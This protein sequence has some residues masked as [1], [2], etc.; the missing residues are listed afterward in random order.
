MWDFEKLAYLI[1]SIIVSGP[2]SVLVKDYQLLLDNTAN[3]L[4]KYEIS[5]I[6]DVLST[7]N[8]SGRS[9]PEALSF[10]CDF[11]LK[12]LSIE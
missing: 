4:E 7:G 11:T 12:L 3:I 2:F 9:D 1:L 6:A 8:K 5:N 10:S